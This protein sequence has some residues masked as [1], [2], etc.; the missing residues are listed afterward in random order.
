MSDEIKIYLGDLGYYNDHNFNQ[1]TP[2]NVAYVGGYT[3]R[4]IPE[5][6]VELFKNPLQLIERLHEKQPHILALSHYQWNSNLNLKILELA[7]ML[8]PRTVGILGGP[9]FNT[10]DKDRAC[11]FFANRPMIDFC[12][13][14]EGE[15][16]FRQLVE[17]LIGANFD[18][19]R[20]PFDKRP[21]TI[22]SYDHAS[23]RLMNNPALRV[24]RLDLTS[25]ESPY[26]D[27]SMDIFLDDRF[28]APIIET[29]RGCPY[30]CSYC[31][32]GNAINSKVRQFPM[33]QVIEE[34]R[35]VSRKSQNPQKLLY[36]ADANFGILK[37]DEDIA[38]AMAD[39]TENLGF[40]KSTYVYYAKN[41]ND[42]VIRVAELMKT[43]TSMSMSK[44]S[45]NQD[46]LANIK[47]SNIPHEQYD[48]LR[49][50]CEKRGIS[51]FC[52]LIFGLPGETYDSFIKGVIKTVREG[53]E[54]AMYPL[55]L[56]EGAEN[57]NEEERQNFG[58]KTKFR[59]CPRYISTMEGLPTL[60]YEEV[61]IENNSLP[62][63]D[64]LRIRQFHFF[65]AMFGSE[66][67]IDLR[68]ELAAH[69]LDYATLATLVL[70]DTGNWPKDLLTLFD[71][72]RNAA[73]EE[74][75]DAD[76]IRAEFEPGEMSDIE[77]K[78]PAQN[79]YYLAVLACDRK[80]LDDFNTYLHESVGCLFADQ[81]NEA[82][83]DRLQW[84]LKLCFDRFICYENF[85][86][87]KQVNYPFDIESWRT[88]PSDHTV[89]SPDLAHGAKYQLRA[90]PV[91]ETRL[92][93]LLSSG[94]KLHE[95]VYKLRNGFIGFR[96][97]MVFAYE[98]KAVLES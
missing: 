70:E 83:I 65:I 96:G 28:L 87:E 32:W 75:M 12:I 48:Y 6:Q 88:S 86:S 85:Q 1:P 39:C 25:L 81:A 3:K 7:K 62:F 27:G 15:E 95:A 64:W 56:L 89:S 73:I 41:T 58:I 38:K 53:A 9:H 40:P 82:V 16:S 49:L 93:D 74:L 72:F 60:E 78:Y 19:S 92:G 51:T 14:Q 67:F 76:Q 31:V 55:L 29:N 26:L 66:V 84:A 24:E 94:L 34:I 21:S 71:K 10:T 79:Y 47:R 46:V 36:L 42:R 54:I 50:E 63:K 18:L 8:D 52:E 97:H 91:I 35:Y 37:R 30:S 13:G 77:L 61:A 20:L 22:F 69:D 43:V 68:R 45:T 2:L 33:E 5:A 4:A 98:R 17:L 11:E 44:Q 23:G 80:L 59:V 90:D 57:H